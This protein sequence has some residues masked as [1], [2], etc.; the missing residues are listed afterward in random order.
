MLDRSNKSATCKS[1]NSSSRLRA[2][3]LW[4]GSKPSSR[5][6]AEAQAPKYFEVPKASSEDTVTYSFIVD[7]VRQRC[8]LLTY[9]GDPVADLIY[10]DCEVTLPQSVMRLKELDATGDKTKSFRPVNPYEHETEGLLFDDRGR[11]IDKGGKVSSSGNN[12]NV[13]DNDEK[14]SQ[15]IE[16]L[17]IFETD[18]NEWKSYCYYSDFAPNWE[19]VD[20]GN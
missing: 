7:K 18:D 15:W 8:K 3:P 5:L 13:M 11:T 4:M 12:E 14:I 19:T 20:F 16:S 2:D 6:L 1:R 10:P 17:P 9:L